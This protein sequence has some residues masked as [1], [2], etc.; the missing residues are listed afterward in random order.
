[1]TR[2]A[3]LAGALVVLSVAASSH[4]SAPKWTVLRIECLSISKTAGQCAVGLFGTYPS[5]QA[6]LA[7]NGGQLET[8]AVKNDMLIDDRCEVLIQQR[9]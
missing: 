4:A 2:I 9:Q 5:R 6:C 8:K 3:P 1:M 7:A